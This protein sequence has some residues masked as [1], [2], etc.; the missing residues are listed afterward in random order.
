M[1]S[2]CVSKTTSSLTEKA[3]PIVAVQRYVDLGLEY[4]KRDDFYR[5]RKHL[6][7]ALEIDNQDPSANAALALI[8]HHDGE[9]KKAEE[10]FLKALKS[11][12]DY[13]RGRSYYAA[14]L[15]AE[16]RFQDALE[17]FLLAADD[18]DYQG[19]SQIYSNIALCHLKLGQLQQA[20]DAY[21]KTLRL[22]RF[23][24]KALFGI[25]EILIQTE[26]FKSAQHYYNRLVRLIR[27]RGMQHSAKS[28]W[29][30]VRIADYFGS[31]QQVESLSGL[32]NE[33]Y[34]DSEENAIRLRRVNLESNND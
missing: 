11:N 17:H 6:N 16:K 15:F 32:L 21:T 4:I 28:L 14:F 23:D 8:Y 27:E 29:L 34:P 31:N 20:I 10:L 9:V 33:M 22:D 5:A 1:M 3:D 18:S 7:R 2:A 25:S 13:T 19:R 12:P 24:A 30:G 26:D